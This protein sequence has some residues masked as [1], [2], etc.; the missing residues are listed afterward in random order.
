MERGVRKNG[1][2]AKGKGRQEREG[3]MSKMIAKWEEMKGNRVHEE[4]H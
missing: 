2:N 4:Y 1:V 3:K